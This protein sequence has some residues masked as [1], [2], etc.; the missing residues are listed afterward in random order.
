MDS[1]ERGRL[2]G[3]AALWRGAF[4]L[5]LSHK[6]LRGAGLRPIFAYVATALACVTLTLALSP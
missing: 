4:I 3:G 5:T 6:G 2:A 1:W